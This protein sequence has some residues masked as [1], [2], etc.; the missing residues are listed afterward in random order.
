MLASLCSRPLESCS[1]RAGSKQSRSRTRGKGRNCGAARRR[2]CMV[3]AVDEAVVGI[4]LAVVG[5]LALGSLALQVRGLTGRV[6][7]LEKA[8]QVERRHREHLTG[9]V[10][11]LQDRAAERSEERERLEDASELPRPRFPQ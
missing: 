9:Q 6:K 10:E 1:A 7:S 8:R 4:S 5:L 11:R 3:D 2:W